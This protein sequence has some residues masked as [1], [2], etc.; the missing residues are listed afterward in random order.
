M[1]SARP[2]LAAVVALVGFLFPAAPAQVALVEPTCNVNVQLSFS[3]ALTATQT[4]ASVT[5]VANVVNC[6][7]PSGNY[8]N[9]Q[10]GTVSDATGSV[11]SLGGVPCNLLATITGRATIDWAPTGGHTTF[12]FTVNT[13]PLNGLVTL[14]T[15]QTSGPLTGTTS[16]TVGAANPNLGCALGGLSSLTVPIGQTTFL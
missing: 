16:L 15:K 4:T 10:S 11:V 2:A 14:Q 3:P 13:N 6:L 7:S 9:L 8:S 5:G 1:P 12:D